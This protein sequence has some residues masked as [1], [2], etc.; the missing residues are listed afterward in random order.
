MKSK[1]KIKHMIGY[2]SGKTDYANIMTELCGY[3]NYRF[4]RVARFIKKFAQ[5]KKIVKELDSIDPKKL[6]W[7]PSC[8][9][10]KPEN[11]DYISFRAMMELN[12]ILSTVDE[13]KDI[14][15]NIIEVI[16]IACFSENN[17]DI[18]YD[19][20]IDRFKE[21]RDLVKEQPFLD[22][23]GLYNW[24]EN[25]LKQS[26]QTWEERFLSVKIED[27][28]YD[29][30]HGERMN[31]FNIINTIRTI[32][33]DFNVDYEKAWQV[34]YALTQTNSY[35]KATAA[36]IQDQIRVIKEAKMKAERDRKT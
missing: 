34:S 24:I 22:M 7:S 12:T 10:N 4:R 15:E 27:P 33:N 29:K 21:F 3:K 32:C 23:M 19:S 28:D 14:I 18:D 13:D 5:A 30:A 6:Q 17:L 16:S 26:T 1:V 11:I 36:H 9:I 8:K 2:L 20:S 35:S 31:Q 25:S